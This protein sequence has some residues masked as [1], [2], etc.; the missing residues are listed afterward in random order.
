VNV[1]LTTSYDGVMAT[2]VI[3]VTSKMKVINKTGEQ[4]IPIYA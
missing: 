2:D 1:I 3:N 4:I